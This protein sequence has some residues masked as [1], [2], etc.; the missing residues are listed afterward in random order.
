MAFF[1]FARLHQRMKPPM[2]RS[3]T[4]RAISPHTVML[5]VAAPQAMAR[6]S[7]AVMAAVPKFSSRMGRSSLV[8]NLM[9]P[10]TK[11]MIAQNAIMMPLMR[12]ERFALQ[13]KSAQMPK[14]KSSTPQMMR[15]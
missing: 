12:R 5:L 3:D 11:S 7:C 2:K 4:A 14:N 8:G 9:E 15:T 13:V 1:F 10:V 6:I